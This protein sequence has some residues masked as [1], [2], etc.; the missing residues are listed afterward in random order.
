MVKTGIILLFINL[1]VICTFSQT[2][3]VKITIIEDK[4]SIKKLLNEISSQSGLNF[5][6]NPNIMD[7]N[8]EISFH[9]RNA[10]I[11][12]VMEKLTSKIPLDY[13]FI[14]NQIVLNKKQETG[15]LESG[16]SEKYTLSGF[17]SDRTSGESLIGAVI[18]AD[19][20]SIGTISNEFGYYSLQLP[21][22]IHKLSFSY[23]GF[24]S[25]TKEM[26]LNNNT[27]H[28]I[29]LSS[30]PQ[31]LPEV[32]IKMPIFD[33]IN[34]MQPGSREINKSE[35]N[36]MPEFG[37]SSGLIKGLQAQ[38]GISIHSDGSAFYFVRGGE[39]D[40]NLI[41]I[42][43][44]PIYN[45][46]HLFGFYSLV[47]PDFTKSIKMYKSDIPVNLGD[48]LSSI[49]D[50]RTK[51]GNLNN[52]ELSGATSLILNRIS[53]E[54][55]ILKGKSS[56]FTSLRLS[57]F[58][59]IYKKYVPYL[60]IGFGDVNVKFNF[61]LNKNNRLFFTLINGFDQLSNTGII[62][63]TSAGIQWSNSALTLR[64]NHIF[65]PKLFSNTI[66]Y[67][68]NYQYKLSATSDAWHSG[69]GSISLK[70]DY[71]WYAA[72]NI[73]A[74]FGLEINNF[75]FNPGKI[76]SGS[77]SG[78]FPTIKQD[79]SKQ[80]VLYGGTIYDFKK[81]IHFSIGTRFSLWNNIGPA[82][83]YTFD[84]HHQLIDTINTSQGVY[85]SYPKID[86][87][88]SVS[89]DIDSNS[90]IKLSYGIYHQY[91]HLITNSTSPFT[92][93]E[94][95]LP[96]SPNIKPQFS[97]QLALGF[98][99]YLPGN[100]LELSSG[101]YYK[102]MYNQIDYKPHPQ[103]LLNPYIEGEL[104]FGKMFSYGIEFMLK[105]NIG[106]LN[107]WLSY[108]FSRTFRQTSEVNKGRTY[109]AFQDRPHDLSLMLN[110]NISRRFMFSLY[111]T[112]YSGS[113]FSSPT[114]FYYF[115]GNR[116]PFYDRKNNDRLPSYKRMDIALKYLFNK[117][118]LSKYRHSISFSIYNLFAFK[119]PVDINFNKVLDENNEAVINANV[120]NQQNLVT[121][122]TILVRFLPSLTYKFEFGK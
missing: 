70:S 43:D 96:S 71:T 47:V 59:W 104:R 76:L 52:F 4:I 7:F 41:I 32:I 29:G 65:N 118:P 19:D 53:L 12:D 86:L 105:K 38:P 68:G 51:D 83:Y 25:E 110:Y 44:A 119:N 28:N 8:R 57:N 50:I 10:N 14:E 34:K 93:F 2:S 101:L 112:Y 35:L 60:N 82:K 1:S 49:L 102:K 27:K 106:K 113:S 78:I 100:G 97:H 37:S 72:K 89:Y 58:N 15:N 56:F 45:P 21:K 81:K 116:V 88:T 24:I 26:E 31:K 3:T 84:N 79:N 122:Q 66:I 62:S 111:W 75:F 92:S 33:I 30:I 74:K 54:G 77:L 40:Q 107:G 99:K 87:R 115:N 98:V 67:S 94:V 20:I 120:L 90:V 108:T 55:P 109:P 5:S 36:N 114:G 117:N 13:I 22:G 9:I 73:T 61:K 48:R 11:E 23:L 18:Y 103:T 42:D 121:T 64:W 95:W 63:G 91:L 69:I 16:T 80:T 85:N 17:I 39:K 6:Y 46:A